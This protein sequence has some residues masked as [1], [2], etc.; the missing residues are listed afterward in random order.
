MIQQSVPQKETCKLETNLWSLSMRYS[1]T[2]VSLRASKIS[3]PTIAPPNNIILTAPY[4]EFLEL[5]CHEMLIRP[6]RGNPDY[7][8]S[9]GFALVTAYVDV[10]HLFKYSHTIFVETYLFVPS[11]DLYYGQF[12]ACQ[13]V[14]KGLSFHHNIFKYYFCRQLL[15]CT[16]LNLYYGQFGAC[17]EVVKRLSQTVANLQFVK[18]LSKGCHSTITM[19]TL[20]TKYGPFAVCKILVIGYHQLVI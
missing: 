5:K 18:K 13:E 11:L 17:Q 19:T 9:W 1:S 16:S 4:W 7:V 12:A 20:D 15:V 2:S 8:T 6:T 14:V 3:L 10:F